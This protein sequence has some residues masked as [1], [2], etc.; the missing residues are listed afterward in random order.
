M[1][2][3]PW[4]TP[5]LIVLVRSMPEEE[6]LTACKSG[7]SLGASSTVVDCASFWKSGRTNCT[8]GSCAASAAS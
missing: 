3:K 5:K 2:K 7:T 1:S 4:V 8:A 6:V